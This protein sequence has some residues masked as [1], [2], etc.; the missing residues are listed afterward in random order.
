MRDPIP[1][2]N[3]LHALSRRTQL[4]TKYKVLRPQVRRDTWTRDGRRCR[5]CR[6]LVQL[7]S[8]D[9]WQLANIHEITG[10]AARK[11]EAI[12]ITLRSTI[13]LCKTC[14]DYVERH[15]L[16]ADPVVPAEGFNGPVLFTGKISPL[17][18]AYRH[19]SRP[20][21]SPQEAR[22]TSGDDT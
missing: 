12:D 5:A 20:E 21:M 4:K 15:E 10:G 11:T 16:H 8:D 22:S 13:T 19:L 7:L 3:P 17:N 14:H 1:K 18:R 6:K 9:P 2:I